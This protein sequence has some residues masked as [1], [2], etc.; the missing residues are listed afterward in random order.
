[1]A[2]AHKAQPASTERLSTKPNQNR[3]AFSKLPNALARPLDSDSELDVRPYCHI[4][5]GRGEC[6]GWWEM[7]AEKRPREEDFDDDEDD[8][9]DGL[10]LP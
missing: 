3:S 8:D 5:C 1:V 10:G 9:D 7:P 4:A 2:N 6:G